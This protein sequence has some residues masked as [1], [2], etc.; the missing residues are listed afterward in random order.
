MKFSHVIKEKLN[1]DGLMMVASFPWLDAAFKRLLVATR[2]RACIDRNRY[3]L[4]SNGIFTIPFLHLL[5]IGRNRCQRTTSNPCDVFK[6]G[7]KVADYVYTG[8]GK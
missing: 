5:A 6:L 1:K 4:S 7:A 3:P 8:S 2:A